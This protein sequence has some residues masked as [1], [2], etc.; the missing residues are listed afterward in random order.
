MANL[1]KLQQLVKKQSGASP[2][3]LHTKYRELHGSLLC[4]SHFLEAQHGAC[5][6]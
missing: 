1:E 3:Q 6:F 5:R 2:F 4:H